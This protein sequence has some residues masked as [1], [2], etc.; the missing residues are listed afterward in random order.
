M[1]QIDSREITA[2]AQTLKRA[3]GSVG[4]KM[5]AALRKA[6]FSIERDAKILA[7]VDTGTLQGSI[8]TTVTGDGRHGAMEAVIGPTVEY[9]PFVEFGTSRTAPQ[10]FLGPATDRHLPGLEQAFVKIM[11]IGR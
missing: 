4:A 10:A 6:A 2:W 1:T 8:S 11:E 3:S 7:P 5:S 9:A